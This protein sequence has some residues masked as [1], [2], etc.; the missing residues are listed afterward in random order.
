MDRQTPQVATT[1]GNV[2]TICLPEAACTQTT[3]TITVSQCD[4]YTVPSGDET[5]TATGMY[6]DTILNMA[7]CDSVI[8]IDLNDSSY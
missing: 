3:N 5:H 7:G 2:L 8:T 1:D 6:N 4:S